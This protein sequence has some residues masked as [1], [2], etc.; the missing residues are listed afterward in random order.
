MQHGPFPPPE[1]AADP[2]GASWLMAEAQDDAALYQLYML[3]DSL[4][5]D[6]AQ[7]MVSDKVYAT[8]HSRLEYEIARH[9]GRKMIP[10]LLQRLRDTDE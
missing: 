7:A 1:L 2:V 3:R 6:R 8:N 5:E 9:I 4:M 10:E